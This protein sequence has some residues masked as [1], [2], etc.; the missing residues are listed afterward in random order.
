MGR[1]L[2]MLALP[3]FVYWLWISLAF[4]DGAPALSIP[5]GAL[6]AARPTAGTLLLYIGW[7]AFQAALALVLPG[8]VVEGTPLADGSRLHYRLNGWLAFCITLALAVLAALTGVLPAALAWERFGAL[9][10]AAN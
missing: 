2:L 8:R 9:L 4:H 6:A 1:V 5:A 10:T 7:W 3:P